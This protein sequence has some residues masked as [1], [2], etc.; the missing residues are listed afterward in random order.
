MAKVDEISRK[1]TE[2]EAREI[3]YAATR[4][5]LIGCGMEVLTEQ[6]F[7]ATGLD[8]LLRCTSM[9]KG[10]FY[11][12]FGSTADFGRE[13]MKAY[14]SF[15]CH[16]LERAPERRSTG[17]IR[18]D[19]DLHKRCQGQMAKHGYARLPGPEPRSGGQGVARRP[20]RFAEQD[21]AGLKVARCLV[22]AHEAVEV[23]VSADTMLWRSFS[24]SVGKG[25]VMRARLVKN[26]ASPDTLIAGFIAD[27]PRTYRSNARRK[28]KS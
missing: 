25:A 2:L 12:Y 5:V 1:T 14:Y 6:G 10:S 13:V 18:A 8:P 27:L 9:P 22:L 15:F 11:D 26:G 3:G 21:R 28:K 16:K 23:D 24:E 20:P 4:E 19:G 7:A 17:D